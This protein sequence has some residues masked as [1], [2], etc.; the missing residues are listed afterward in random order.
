MTGDEL[1]EQMRG[2]GFKEQMLML[3]DDQKLW[4]GTFGEPLLERLS[5]WHLASCATAVVAGTS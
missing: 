5:L 2:I 4:L 3:V 1:Q